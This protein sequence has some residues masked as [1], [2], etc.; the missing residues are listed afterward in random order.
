MPETAIAPQQALVIPRADL[1][2]EETVARFVAE[3]WRG[4]VDAGAADEG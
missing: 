3:M 2:R 4:F 1:T